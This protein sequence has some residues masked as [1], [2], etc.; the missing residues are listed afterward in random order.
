LGQQQRCQRNGSG[1]LAW[2][3]LND[4]MSDIVH[5]DVLVDEVNMGSSGDDDWL[6]QSSLAAPFDC[7]FK[8][9]F[10]TDQVEERLRLFR[11]APRP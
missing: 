8:E 3:R 4:D 11:S 7:F 9:R 1:R 5:R 2:L 10:G 6:L